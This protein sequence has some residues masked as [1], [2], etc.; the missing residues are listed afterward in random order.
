MAHNGVTYNVA[1]SNGCALF[2]NKVPV[3]HSLTNVEISDMEKSITSKPATIIY[4]TNFVWKK[5]QIS[6]EGISPYNIVLEIGFI[7]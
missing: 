1:K 3:A 7:V 2:G 5:L 6:P 4:I